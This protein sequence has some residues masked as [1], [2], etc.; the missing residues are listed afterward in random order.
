MILT[1]LKN[2][3]TFFQE[4]GMNFAFFFGIFGGPEYFWIWTL[5]D[6]KNT[7]IK[8]FESSDLIIQTLSGFRITVRAQS[9]VYGA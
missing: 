7:L 2:A 5:L 6:P 3:T 1:R 9:E 8:V 4:S